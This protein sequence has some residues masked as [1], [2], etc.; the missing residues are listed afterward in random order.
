LQNEEEEY[1]H[2]GKVDK[3]SRTLKRGNTE[4][5]IFGLARRGNGTKGKREGC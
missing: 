5:K 1:G 3:W 2:G 4:K